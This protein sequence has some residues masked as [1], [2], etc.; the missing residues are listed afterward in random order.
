MKNPLHFRPFL[1]ALPVMFAL[2][3]LT[4]SVIACSC[5]SPTLETAVE[6]ASYIVILKIQ[7]VEKYPKG[8]KGYGAGGIKQSRL[9]VEKVFKGN[10]KI[11]QELLFAQGGGADCLWT[12]DEDDID[13]EYLFFLSKNPVK[14]NFWLGFTCSRSGSLKGAAEDLMYLEKMSEVQG[15]TRLAGTIDLETK[16]AVE[17]ETWSYKR[18]AGRT[19]TISGNGK[20]IN[21][22]T[23]ENGVY[24]IYDLPAGKYKVTPEKVTGYKFNDQTENSVEVK[25]EPKSLTEQ[26]FEYTIDNSITGKFL[27]SKG[28]PLHGVYLDLLPA[29]GNPPQ[30]F[31]QGDATDENGVF[32]FTEIPAGTYVIVINKENEISARQPFGTFYYPNKTTR[33]DAAELTIG[34]GDHF[35]DLTITAPTTEETITVSGVL[36]FEDGKPVNNQAIEFFNNIEAFNRIGE[37]KQPDSR[38]TTDQNGRFR[39]SILKG[40]KGIMFGSMITYVG[41][42]EKCPKLDKLIKTQSN[43]VT[44]I[45]S[46][47]IQIEADKDQPGIELRFPFPGC[48]KAKID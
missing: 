39:I 28:N 48:K 29:R 26:D 25:I 2:F 6:N 42:Y 24:E 44:E 35:N 7:T 27:D 47:A 1:A 16:P 20:N 12:F 38:V 36:L 9:T 15:K 40:Q 22:K 5:S 43:A 23:D 11:G 33:E 41:E 45:N 46:P 13:R 17:G 18:L 37:S 10:L 19:V 3:F 8:E 31:Y 4:G 32:E 34:A 14:N 30:Y 21:L